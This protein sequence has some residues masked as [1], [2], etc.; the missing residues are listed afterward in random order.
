MFSVLSKYLAAER[1]DV[2]YVAIGNHLGVPAD[3]VKRLLHRLRE[4]YRAILREE[5]SHTVES[6][7]AVD[8][9]I[10]YL[11]AVLASDEPKHVQ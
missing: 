2:S 3:A 9:E 5:V 1:R 7:S 8:E 4:R 10:R 6:T 11:C